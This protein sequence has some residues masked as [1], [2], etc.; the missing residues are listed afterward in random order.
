[1]H[2]TLGAQKA[3][4]SNWLKWDSF[5]LA[6]HWRVAQRSRTAT[7]CCFF[8]RLFWL[9]STF[10]ICTY[11][12][13]LLGF[14]YF[15]IFIHL[16][17]ILYM[18]ICIYSW[19]CALQFSSRVSFLFILFYFR[20]YFILQFFLCLSLSFFVELPNLGFT[21]SHSMHNVIKVRMYVD[22]FVKYLYT[23]VCREK[24]R[25]SKAI[26]PHFLVILLYYAADASGNFL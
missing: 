6:G 21:L 26:F 25:N 20:F 1:M 19:Y 12:F 11:E 14:S 15:C 9:F 5:C 17:C 16:F 7:L 8:F 23:P 22:S 24:M 2:L 4:W 10:E 18:Y 3:K 13:I